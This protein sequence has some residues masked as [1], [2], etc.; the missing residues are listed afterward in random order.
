MI[1]YLSVALT[2]TDTASARSLVAGVCIQLLLLA[3][4]TKLRRGADTGADLGPGPIVQSVLRVQGVPTRIDHRRSAPDGCEL[5][6]S[7]GG[8][9]T[10]CSCLRY[11]E[12]SSLGVAACVQQSASEFPTLLRRLPRSA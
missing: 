12:A 7:A 11:A 6:E 9:E 3:Y 4:D 5:R 2:D 8:A 10:S 1:G